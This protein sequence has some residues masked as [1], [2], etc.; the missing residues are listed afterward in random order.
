MIVTGN[1][2]AKQTI[3]ISAGIHGNEDA[4]PLAVLDFLRSY[5]TN[6]DDPKIIFFPVANPTGFHED[7]YLN[8]NGQNLNRNFGKKKLTDENHMLYTAIMNEPISFFLSLHEDDELSGG[9]IHAYYDQ[10]KIPAIYKDLIQ[11]IAKT[12]PIY[13]KD[14]IHNYK[15]I[16]G[17]VSNP[18]P[19][20]SFEFIMNRDG[21]K[22]SVCLEI[23]DRIPLSK[24][25]ETNL[26]V[27]EKVIDFSKISR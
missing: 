9:Y 24:R 26:S 1:K 20:G 7:T 21:V 5:K 10:T 6:K 8:I 16:N 22:H 19:D 11:V 18:A 13:T 2:R 17:I 14:R 23:P 15:A 27:I 4:G 3:C 25:V 12:C